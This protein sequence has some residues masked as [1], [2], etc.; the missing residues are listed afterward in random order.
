MFEQTISNLEQRCKNL[1]VSQ[2]NLT[3]NCNDLASSLKTMEDKNSSLQKSYFTLEGDYSNLQQKFYKLEENNA[4]LQERIVKLEMNDKTFSEEIE[5]HK[6]RHLESEA[7]LKDYKEHK[8]QIIQK[9]DS[10]ESKTNS[11]LEM[12]HINKER[13]NK[14]ANLSSNL[15]LEMTSMKEE[16]IVSMQKIST[17]MIEQKESVQH[18]HELISIKQSS[19]DQ[20]SHRCAKLDDDN[21]SI[22]QRLNSF[23]DGRKHDLNTITQREN[24]LAQDMTKLWNRVNDNHERVGEMFEIFKKDNVDRN[25]YI[26]ENFKATSEKVFNLEKAHQQQLQVNSLLENFDKKISLMDEQR[27]QSEAR[28]RDEVDASMLQYNKNFELLTQDFD[29]KLGQFNISIQKDYDNLQKLSNSLNA[30]LRDLHL[31]H[32]KLS[33]R[34]DE[35]STVSKRMFDELQQSI[36]NNLKIIEEKHRSE[37][38]RIET[39]LQENTFIQAEKVNNFETE[40]GKKLKEQEINNGKLKSSFDDTILTFRSAFDEKIKELEGKSA[41]NTQ[42]LVEIEPIAKSM[43]N[44]LD[45]VRKEII[46]ESHKHFESFKSEVSTTMMK[47]T[48]KNN[49]VEKH[50][51]KLVDNNTQIKEELVE[52]LKKEQ[53][54]QIE[55]V[56]SIQEDTDKSLQSTQE[57]MT[58]LNE[59]LQE[60]AMNDKLAKAEIT[61]L[62]GKIDDSNSKL[63]NLESADLFLQESH[64]QLTEKSLKIENDLKEAKY[65]FIASSSDLKKDLDGKIQLNWEN[66]KEDAKDIAASLNKMNKEI[67]GKT[68]YRIETGMFTKRQ[69]L[70][71]CQYAMLLFTCI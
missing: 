56:K 29:T 40:T 61:E 35:D 50:Y 44:R 63:T 67:I 39:Q 6:K 15:E 65:E 25:H 58:S 37:F 38:E 66:M 8:E 10:L 14:I 70:L 71:S 13:I 32:A 33:N 5:I 18:L 24:D 60:L 43:N 16:S 7:T 22:N 52:M 1:E 28:A 23:A 51:E 31:N 34:V 45:E 26:E 57:L 47:V 54:L 9:V 62:K 27:Q 30:D 12:I 3:S 68:L 49:T 55:R 41:S 17:S 48:E 36:Q 64:R 59:K 4:Q 69:E 11:N 20:L 19:I 46:I 21:N 42:A 2:T 53:H